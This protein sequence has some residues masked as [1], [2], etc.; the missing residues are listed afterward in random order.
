M[1][2][3]RKIVEDKLEK[4]DIVDCKVLKNPVKDH[5]IVAD[6]TGCILLQSEQILKENSAYK[7]IKPIVDQDPQKLTKN[8]KFAA[9]KLEMKVKVIT[10]STEIENRIMEMIGSKETEDDSIENMNDFAIIESLE[11]NGVSEDFFLMVT[12]ILRT[13]SAKFGTYKIVACKDIKSQRNTINLYNNFQ[14]MVTS[15]GI[16]KFSKLKVNNFKKDEED[17]HRLSSTFSTKIVDASTK[18]KGL[19]EKNGVILGDKKMNAT[20]LGVANLKCY[21]SCMSAE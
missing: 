3:I 8:P 6:E 20:I 19:L 21:E 10:L 11:I 17:Y 12:N 4:A 14:N 2:K 7:L 16:Y 13:M 15:G 18:E 5:Y 9:V 1:V